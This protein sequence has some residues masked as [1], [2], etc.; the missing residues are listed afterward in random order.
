MLHD[1]SRLGVLI[2]ID[3]FWASTSELLPQLPAL[4]AVK[5]DVSHGSGSPR[6]ELELRRVVASAREAGVPAIAK[7]VESSADRAFATALGFDLMQ[8]NEFSRPVSGEDFTHIEQGG[9]T[10]SGG[11]GPDGGQFASWGDSSY[12]NVA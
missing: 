8:G 2:V 11:D 1:A 9:L 12:R 6:A 3:D 5:V 4:H 7:R 10:G